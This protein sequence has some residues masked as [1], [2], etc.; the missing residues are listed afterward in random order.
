MYG[1]YKTKLTKC[2]L[3]N[4]V[5][6]KTFN[7]IVTLNFCFKQGFATICRIMAVYVVCN[8]MDRNFPDLHFTLSDVI[9]NLYQRL[10]EQYHWFLHLKQI[11][12]EWLFK[13][14][15]LKKIL[16]SLSYGI[17]KTRCLLLKISIC[18][19]WPYIAFLSVTS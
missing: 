5:K 8:L 11:T 4:L 17:L 7:F 10:H 16:L 9:G 3:L 6:W 13:I 2:F 15:I 18:Y 19:S 12:V 14:L 1:S